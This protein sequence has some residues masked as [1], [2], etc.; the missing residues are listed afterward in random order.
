MSVVGW[1]IYDAQLVFSQRPGDK[2]QKFPDTRSKIFVSNQVL[3]S[4]NWG[5]KNRPALI[6][7]KACVLPVVIAAYKSDCPPLNFE[8]CSLLLLISRSFWFQTTPISR[9]KKKKKYPFC[10]NANSIQ[11]C[12]PS[13]FDRE[14]PY[15]C[16]H[17]CLF[18]LPNLATSLFLA[19]FVPSKVHVIL[20]TAIIFCLNFPY[21]LD[22][23]PLH[24]H[25]LIPQGSTG[26]STFFAVKWRPIF[27]SL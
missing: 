2:I 13:L 6:Y 4:I 19:G 25:N 17:F 12:Q 8:N 27:F 18:W 20:K 21:F 9:F 5:G 1:N 14:A 22:I 10:L 23:F 26:S 24:S 15:F 16:E 7:G 11:R 3:K